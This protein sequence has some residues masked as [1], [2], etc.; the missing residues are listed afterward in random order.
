MVWQ[1]TWIP[2]GPTG[3]SNLFS[4]YGYR[5]G[6]CAGSLF[7]KLR[8]MI[9]TTPVLFA[10]W[11]ICIGRSLGNKKQKNY[12]NREWTETKERDY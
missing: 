2:P 1:R 3:L 9:E 11:G 12:A 6:A 4:Y 10:H 8:G 5:W 7:S